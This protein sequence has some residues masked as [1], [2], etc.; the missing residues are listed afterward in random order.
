MKT[1]LSSFLKKN[2]NYKILQGWEGAQFIPESSAE[3]TL[4]QK[5]VFIFVLF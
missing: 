1:K 2:G 5:K 3:H 4:C